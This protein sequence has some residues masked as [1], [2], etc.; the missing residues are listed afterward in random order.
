MTDA[1]LGLNTLIKHDGNSKYIVARDVRIFLKDKPI[2]S[3]K[4]IVCRG[5]TCCRGKKSDSI[6]W[7]YMIKFTWPSDKRQREGELLKLAKERGVTDIAVWFN[8]KQIIIDDDPDTISHFR[9]DMKF[10]ALGK[11]SSKASWVDSSPE[12]SRAY[13]KTSLRERS[14]SGA[15]YLIGLG[16]SASSVTT[17]SS[18]QKKKKR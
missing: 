13:S 2:A 16:I 3:T 1:E 17:S 6:E 8:H 10:G 14:G 4:A 18:G 5:T 12:S 11:L 9:R 15:T 7:E